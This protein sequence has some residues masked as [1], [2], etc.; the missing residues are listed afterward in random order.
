MEQVLIRIQKQIKNKSEFFIL[1]GQERVAL[2]NIVS[3]VYE[4]ILHLSY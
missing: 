4:L 3:P 2:G 1:A